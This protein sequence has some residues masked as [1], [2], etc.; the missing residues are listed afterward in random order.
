MGSHRDEEL[1]QE[2]ID[3]AGR[4]KLLLM[5]CDGV[6]TDGRLFFS[7]NGEELKAFDVRDG[8]GIV[9]WHRAGFTSGIITGRESSIVTARAAELG[10]SF[11]RQKV[12]NKGDA[13][14]AV[15]AEAGVS[16]SEAAFI[17]DDVPDIEAM[18]CAGLAIAVHDAVPE[19]KAAAHFI[20]R[21]KGGRGAIREVVDLLL[22][23]R[24]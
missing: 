18:R 6:L 8:Q 20:T 15:I 1:P 24:R 4:I 21:K 23:A 7:A 5:D 22:N 17:G 19:V 14:K 12:A 9:S 16:T 2:V 3:A 10:I 11:V 13:F